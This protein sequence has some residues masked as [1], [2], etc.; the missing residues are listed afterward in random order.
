MPEYL[1]P[2]VYVEEI[3]AGPKPIE[4]VST[5][6]AGAVGM[7]A[8]GPTSGK[9]VLVTSFAD[10]SRKFGGFMLEPEPDILNK[11]AS[12]KTDG[13]RWWQFPLAVKGFFDNGGQRL[14]V[15]RVFAGGG[16]PVNAQNTGNSAQASKIDLAE[17]LIAEI[18]SDATPVN[19]PLSVKLRHLFGIQAGT[20][21]TSLTILDGQ[22]NQI[23]KA[24]VASFDPV[25][26]RVV[27]DTPLPAG[28]DIRAARGD[29]AVIQAP[30][31]VNLAHLKIIAKNR[32]EAGD[33]LYARIRPIVGATVNLLYDKQAQNDPA[34]QTTIEC[35]VLETVVT[36][37]A[38]A[39]PPSTLTGVA[40][41]NAV[42]IGT[43]PYTI[44][45]VDI[46]KNTFTVGGF[47]ASV[48]K[49]T[50]VD[51]TLADNSHV[52]TTVNA[53]NNQT[54]VTVKANGLTGFKDGDH[55]LIGGGEYLLKSPV[56]DKF[57]LQN[58]GGQAVSADWSKGTLV[59][60]LRSAAKKGTGTLSVWGASRLYVGALVELDNGVAKD[61]NTVKDISGDKV[62]LSQ[63]LNN[64]YY[65]GHKIRVAEME[66]TVQYR[67]NGVVQAEEVFSNLRLVGRTATTDRPAYPEYIV[68]Q[69]NQT[70]ALVQLDDGGAEPPNTSLAT[71]PAAGTGSWQ[72]L[73]GGDDKLGALS[74][75][76]F[77]GID[78]GSGNR[79]GIQAFEDI[80]DISII[81]APGIWATTVQSA[82][83]QQC[84]LLKY[85]FAI[86]D[87]QD[88][89]SIEGIQ[90]VRE[91]L[92]TKY[93][94]LYYPW[95]EVRDPLL[96]R[97]VNLAPSG[98]MAGI[99]ARVD[100]DRGVHK[101]PA[102]E[103]IS[104]I[105]K[106]AEDV[107]KRE[108]DILN[109]KGIN[110]LRFFPG[111]GNRVWGARILS[112]DSSWKYINVRRLFI[113]VEKSIDVGTQWVVFEPNDE[114]LWARVRQTV[115]NFLTTVWRSG[116]LQGTKA[117]EAFFV[118]CDRTT[119]TQ[120]DIDNG[121][122]ICHIGIAPVKPAEFVI[123]RIQQKT[124]ES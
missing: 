68:T 120:E 74:T 44:T 112:S 12:D 105:I 41:N 73:A 11:W 103:V 31:A 3:D 111:R 114:P 51:I 80:E 5:S 76:D 24:N 6:T 60:C 121:K 23:L 26:R 89:L 38:A 47:Q 107:N 19:N 93:A 1:S 61:T 45:S 59:Q 79:T 117:D 48:A 106:I 40:K 21:P 67:P 90:A 84:E 9:P 27:L 85:R 29:H 123:F 110:A 88:G 95:V 108:Q 16:I 17:G 72:N 52:K 7:T 15:K 54:T 86:I 63:V 115:T 113:F 37:D 55:V 65:E 64:D 58:L 83:I 36:V 69:V 25:S 28:K 39:A 46:P 96:K 13:G 116:A 34:A 35:V 109:P 4:G 81:L 50:P 43:V 87:S 97:N 104:G 100:V 99:Y 101:A 18:E 77:V 71:L 102:N 33:A 94:A 56:Q 2:G 124:L 75:D 91:T 62:T 92:D 119:M 118:K 30:A 98:H 14:Y 42:M 57:E 20:T 53:M 32:G 122:L 70:S 78:G 10:F 8:F 22:G 49:G 66:L 82:L